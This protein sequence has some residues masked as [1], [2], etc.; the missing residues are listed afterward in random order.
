MKPDTM[1]LLAKAD[2]AVRAAEALLE[3]GDTDFA[4]A[5]AYYA[6]FYAAEAL[7]NERDLKFQT[8]GGVHSAFG[9]LFARTRELDP[10]Y[11][12]WLL[13]AFDRRIRADYEVEAAISRE[14]VE[15]MIAQA[16]EF[17]G[18]VRRHLSPAN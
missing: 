1:K 8:H 18:A 5:R 11:H 12:R 6:M 3:T 16:R 13:D 7:L 15:T 4:A 9:Q 14:G 2:R 10:K 17:I